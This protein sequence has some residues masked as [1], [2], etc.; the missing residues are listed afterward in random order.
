MGASV[1]ASLRVLVRTSGTQVRQNGDGVLGPVGDDA[2]QAGLGVL[3]EPGV[4]ELALLVPAV[5]AE[6]AVGG[7]GDERRGGRVLMRADGVGADCL[8]VGEEPVVFFGSEAVAQER[9]L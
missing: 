1:P 7:G 8:R 3:A 6:S 2:P 5:H 4:L 9:G